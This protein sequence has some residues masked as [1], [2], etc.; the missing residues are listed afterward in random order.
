MEM[1]P[2]VAEVGESHVEGP[3]LVPVRVSSLS[4]GFIREIRCILFH[5]VYTAVYQYQPIR[6][7]REK[8]MLR[9]GE[10]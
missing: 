7:L 1:G 4:L 5:V 10:S 9:P 8:R 2:K 6:L 3:S